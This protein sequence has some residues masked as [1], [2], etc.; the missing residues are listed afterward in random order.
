[1]S[2]GRGT[3]D[4]TGRLTAGAD[5]YGS[6]GEKVGRLV[7]AAASYILVEKGWLF[8]KDLYLPAS[9]I[10]Q[11][12]DDGRVYLAYTKAQAEEM[13]REDLPTEGDAWY[14]TATDR[15]TDTTYGTTGRAGYGADREVREG[16]NV[17]VPVVEEQLKAGVR[18][19]EAGKARIVK[20]VRE[21]QQ[22]LDVPVEREE[23][24]VTERKVDRPATE[25]DLAM[26]EREID[27]PLK[28][29]E[30]V[31]QKEA[32]VTGEVQVRK[33]VQRDT[34]RVTGTVR[35]EDVHVEG[36]DSERVHVQGLSDA[37]RRRY[38]TMSAEEQRRYAGM[39]AADRAAFEREYDARGTG[40]TVTDKREY[41][42][43]GNLVDREHYEEPGTDRGR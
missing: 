4:W 10:A 28:E 20:D 42:S 38:D 35:R 30:V 37:Q 7:Q 3:Y 6:D 11:V 41:D 19:T 23:V 39:S 5:V 15:V 13:G 36:A 21:E 29:Q 31:T 43:K 24:Y 33:E 8:V 27:I 17:S 14:G 18:E 22:T 16:E 9:S 26:R 34:E 32:R 12:D 1:M 25:A 40:K 2:T